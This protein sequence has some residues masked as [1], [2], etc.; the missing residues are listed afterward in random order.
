MAARYC[1]F[2]A[3]K[4]QNQG[5]IQIT[6]MFRQADPNLSRNIKVEISWNSFAPI[7]IKAIQR[8]VGVN[9]NPI[10]VTIFLASRPSP[11]IW[12]NCR[13]VYIMIFFKGLVFSRLQFETTENSNQN[14]FS[15][16][17][18]QGKARVGKG[19]WN[20]ASEIIHGPPT[21][22]SLSLRGGRISFDLANTLSRTPCKCISRVFY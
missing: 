15:L 18:M 21:I 17:P 11:K 20:Q 9:Q 5:L 13:N 12:L 8:Q 3:S 6:V 14:K 2:A 10:L 22:H 7:T 19:I 16:H 4:I 1:L